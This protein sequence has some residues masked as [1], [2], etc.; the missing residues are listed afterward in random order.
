MYCRVIP[1]D[2]FNESKL[3]KCMGRLSLMVHNC[4]TPRGITIDDT[5]DPFEIVLWDA[6]YLEIANLPVFIHDFHV[7]FATIYNNKG[8]Y[9]LYAVYDDEFIRV[10]ND[11]DG[12]A[13]DLSPDF[14]E[15]C[16]H[17]KAEREAAT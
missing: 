17:L 4:K 2:L 8:D 1:R 13:P 16:N 10:F 14:I 3:L 6:G 5:C 7:A 12:F 11:D 15:L 9:P